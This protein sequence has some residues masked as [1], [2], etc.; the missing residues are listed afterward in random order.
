MGK[1][2]KE[3]LLRST[4]AAAH[5]MDRSKGASKSL[6]VLLI[7]P[8]SAGGVRSFLSHVDGEGG[9]SIGYKPPLGIL[10]IATALLSWSNH[11]V[12]VI[13][14][15]AERLSPEDIANRA[16]TF[17]PDVVGISAW[18]DFWYPAYRTGELVKEAVPEAHLTFGG[19]H[20]GIF[21]GET[22][23][24]D[25]VDSVI[26]GDGEVPFVHLCNLV[27]DDRQDNSM[28]GLHFKK[29]GVKPVPD[30]FFIQG[31]LDELPIPDREL[32]SIS[33]YS[34]VLAKGAYTTTMITSRGCPH[35]CTFCKLNF[36]KTL[37]RSAADVLEEFRRIHV[38]GIREVEIYDD[39]FTW[40]KKRLQ[41]ICEGLIEANFGIEWAVRD[42]VSSASMTPE[43]LDLMARAGCRRIHF[44]IESGVQSVIDEM[45]KRTTLEQAE[46]AVSLAKQA[47]MTVLTYFMFGNLGET[48]EDMRKTIDFA[49]LLNGDYAQFSIT[50]PYAGTEMYTSALAE[51]LIEDDYWLAY[52]RNPAANF[53]PPKVIEKYADIKTLMKIRD[54]AVRRFY[55]RPKFVFR[56]VGSISSLAEFVRKARMGMQLVQS[57]YSK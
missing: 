41:E 3:L 4:N 56:Q 9:E 20:L 51:G 16:A 50:I 55:F 52:A 6:R 21:P 44:G 7:Q 47:G 43:L 27:A 19:P 36:Q 22:L 13:D 12:E 10:Y 38:L 28:P 35:R 14:A 37:A 45:K 42:R 53:L 40:S 39:T 8:P 57:V 24:I 29:F 15:Q 48:V 26:V 18:T 25:F 46:K 17:K 34:S 54:E 1:N 2:D 33:N 11:V 23:E 5:L 49:L 30:T 32:L 31:D